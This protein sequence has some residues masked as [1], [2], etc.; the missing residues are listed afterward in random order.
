MHPLE[1][2]SQSRGVEPAGAQK[3]LERLSIL[4][5]ASQAESIAGLD[6]VVRLVA[7]SSRPRLLS[8]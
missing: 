6:K 2:L 7:S 1:S 3:E 4:I 5:S 8:L